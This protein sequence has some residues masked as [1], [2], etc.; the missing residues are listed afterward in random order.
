MFSRWNPP[1][2]Y[3]AVSYEREVPPLPARLVVRDDHAASLVRRN[4]SPDI[5]FHWSVNPYRGCTHACAYCYARRTHEYLDLGAGTDFE[6]VI[7]VKRDAAAL[8]RAH[9][10][11]PSWQGE[12]LNLSGVTD[13]Y[14]PLERRYRLTRAV[15]EVCVAYRNPV[16][17][18]TRSPLV[19]RDLDLLTELAAHHAVRV[20][21]SIP[22]LDAAVARALEPGTA[23][24]AARLRTLATL[25]AA[26]IP[27]GVS[28]API[29]PGLNDHDIA[30]TLDA[31][32]AAGARWA[33][34]S[35]LRLP[36]SVEDVFVARLRQALPGRAEAV[37]DRLRRA[38]GG[39]L[40]DNRFGERMKGHDAVWALTEQ[41]FARETA[42]RGMDLPRHHVGPSPFR[43]PG[44]GVQ[45]GLW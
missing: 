7:L 12:E 35:L 5:G 45:L 1:N 29:I 33:W 31:A 23:P 30:P 6:R 40:T 39:A 38:R 28:L 17:I 41:V 11:K 18:I 37:L 25:S 16:S 15:L 21:V 13:C 8:L 14:Q 24:P 4:Q 22:L 26:G 10:D 3:H 32:H 34:M 43:R 44:A 19:V 36:G 2:P 42:R 27:V 9:L 20:Q